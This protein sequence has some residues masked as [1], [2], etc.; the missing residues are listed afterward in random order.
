MK[1]PNQANPNEEKK[2]SRD[3]KKLL[4]LLLL[5]LISVLLIITICITVWALF[6]RENPSLI[7]PDYAPPDKEPNAEDIGDKD[8]PKLPQQEGG[9]AVSLTYTT[10]VQVYLSEGYASLYFANPSKSNQD[11]VI[12]IVVKDVVIAQSGTISPGKRVEKLDLQP[13][14]KSALAAGGYNGEFKIYYYQP[15]THERT[16]VNTEIPITI[17]VVA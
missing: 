4:L 1:S 8:D 7:P 14:A 13:G 15:D 11:I 17:T 9:G 12:Q 3:K 16:I 2:D 5:L 6:F 10:K